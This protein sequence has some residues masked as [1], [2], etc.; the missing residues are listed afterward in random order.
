MYLLRELGYS[1]NHQWLVPAIGEQYILATSS[2]Q[3]EF[4][5]P[6]VMWIPELTQRSRLTLPKM[7]RVLCAR[8][9][10]L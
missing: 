2:R 10:T 7:T 4:Q 9:S 3:L 5:F 6:Q 1:F 8:V